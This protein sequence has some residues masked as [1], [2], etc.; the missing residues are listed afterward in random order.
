M[1]KY[2]VMADSVR[3][4]ECDGSGKKIYGR[5][6]WRRCDDCKGTGRKQGLPPDSEKEA[7]E[8][9]KQLGRSNG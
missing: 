9:N 4:P 5:R 1:E 8:L 7:A 3:C 6:H 2:G